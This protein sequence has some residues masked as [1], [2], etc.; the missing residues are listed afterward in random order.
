MPALQG[1]AAADRDGDDVHANIL[2]HF[3]LNALW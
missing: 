3:G 1:A 2:A